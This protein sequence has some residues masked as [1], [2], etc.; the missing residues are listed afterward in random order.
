MYAI[1]GATGHIGQKIAAFL[2]GRGKPVTVIGRSPERL[3]PLVDRGA[4]AAVGTLED[5]GFLTRAFT[6]ARGVFAMIPPNYQVDDFR[7]FQNR[8][9]AAIAVAVGASGVSHV[10]HLSSVGGHLDRGNGPIAG[11]HDQEERLNA[12]G[13]VAVVHL[14]PAFFMENCLFNI[15]LIRGQGINGTPLKPDLKFPSIATQDIARVA[16]DYLLTVAFSGHSIRE[17]LGPRDL[18]MA[19]MTRLLGQAIGKP[20]LPYVQVPYDEAE[21]ALKAMGASADVARL[22]VEMYRAFN[23]GTMLRGIVRRPEN[24]TET[25]F[26]QFAQEF[27][28]IY[29]QG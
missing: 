1:T 5:A 22:Y 9:G 26:E 23:E 29:K 7:A 11:L 13:N 3:Q 15:G 18:S 21:R 20:A 2:L 12:L 19:E 4:T 8:V 14:R 10:V 28:A 6:G 27:A 24:T 25:R 16:G 17:L